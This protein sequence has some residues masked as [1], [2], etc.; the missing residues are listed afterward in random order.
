MKKRV[1]VPLA[2]GFE[3]ME[4]VIVVDVLRRAGL[5]VA[6]AGLAGVGPVLGSRGITVHAEVDWDDAVGEAYDAIVLP[7]GLGGTYTLRD[8]ERVV[9]AVRR[10]HDDG[11]LTA[12]VCA[13]PLVLARA[14]LADGR[15]ITSHPSV[16]DELA[17]AGAAVDDGRVV[18]DG[19]LLT[20]QGP[21]TAMEFAL[22]VAAE[23]AGEDVAAEVSAAMCR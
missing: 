13:A 5:D 9:D 20:S 14:G 8:D 12:A 7:G 6:V 1:I 19:A 2:E 22:A 15:R 21:G 23:L 10:T 11:R 17:G 18:R 16:R 4:A 3:E